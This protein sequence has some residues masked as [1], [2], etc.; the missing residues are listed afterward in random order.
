MT[1]PLFGN[2]PTQIPWIVF[3][4]PQSMASSKQMTP[5]VAGPPQI[6]PSHAE[7]FEG[8]C[9]LGS[10]SSA[11]VFAATVCH[12]LAEAEPVVGD[13]PHRNAAMTV[14]GDIVREAAGAALPQGTPV[15][16]IPLHPERLER[17]R[18]ISTK[19]PALLP[20]TLRRDPLTEREAAIGAVL[21]RN[22]A[23]PRH[24]DVPRQRI[25]PNCPLGRVIANYPHEP[26]SIQL[27]D[28]RGHK[29]ALTTTLSL[30]L[31]PDAEG[32]TVVGDVPRRNGEMP[33]SCPIGPQMVE[34]VRPR[35]R[36]A[37]RRGGP[38]RKLHVL[39]ASDQ[40]QTPTTESSPATSTVAQ[41]LN[42]QQLTLRHP[43]PVQQTSQTDHTS[44]TTVCGRAEPS[45]AS[46][47]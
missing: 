37:S 45:I 17:C 40:R 16:R 1:I 42:R 28:S 20:S 34:S 21:T 15:T 24:G 47:K 46:R 4:A 14:G 13:E 2:Q 30:G 32:E 7:R 19:P 33:M 35:R 23:V 36:C 38:H 39:M 18:T 9:L 6:S 11:G 25:E 44:C 43:A 3:V 10:E 31:D 29:P 41:H 12:P 22:Q 5:S 26:Q 27:G 8:G